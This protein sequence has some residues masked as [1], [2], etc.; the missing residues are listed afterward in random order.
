MD[1]DG[2]M[3]EDDGKVLLLVSEGQPT[4]TWLGDD[5]TARLLLNLATFRVDVFPLTE[6]R[7]V[8]LSCRTIGNECLVMKRVNTGQ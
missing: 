4:E 8:G 3:A 1:D 2:D 7:K 5:G 6:E